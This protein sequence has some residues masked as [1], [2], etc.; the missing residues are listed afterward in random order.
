MQRM[1]IVT[2]VHYIAR[3]I[4]LGLTLVGCKIGILI[5]QLK[6]NSNSA[7]LSFYIRF[8]PESPRWLLAMGKVNETME[9]L[10]KAS[11]MNKHPLPAN[12]DKV[13][14]QVSLN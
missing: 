11:K 10:K 9:V 7:D 1:E 8:I 14:N 4:F 2:V 13:L 12:M 3:C 6:N 5:N